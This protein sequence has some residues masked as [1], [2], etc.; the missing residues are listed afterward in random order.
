MPLPADVD[1]FKVPNFGVISSELHSV[2]DLILR[3]LHI[4][5]ADTDIV[6]IDIK[7]Y[8]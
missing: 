4:C 1:D 7:I 8:R 5:N 3:E 6:A 2:P